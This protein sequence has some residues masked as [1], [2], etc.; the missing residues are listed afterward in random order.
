MLPPVSRSLPLA[1]ATLGL[2]AP[3]FADNPAAR[4]E[5]P[6]VQVVGTTPLPGIGVSLEKV[7]ANVQSVS[8]DDIRRQQPLDLSEQLTQNLSG[9]VASPSQNNPWQPDIAFRGFTASPLMGSPQGLSVFLDGVRVNESFGDT[10]NWDL[11]PPNAIAGTN[12]IPGS[13]PV[14]GLNTLGGTLAVQTKS[15]LKYPGSSMQLMG[16]SW[17]RRNAQF[18]TGGHQDGKD[19]FVAGNF[20]DEDG[21]RQHSASSVN[22]LF[23]KTGFEDDRNDLDVS[24][25]LA[26]NRLN[27]VQALPLAMLDNRRQ[28]YTWPDRTDNRLVMI[29]ARG[30]HFLSDEQ[31]VAGGLYLRSLDNGNLSSN[32]NDNY[33]PLGAPG[34]NNA[35]GTMDRSQTTSRSWGGSLQYTDTHPWHG[36]ENQ[37]TVGVS[38]DFGR[39]DYRQWSAPGDFT[40]DRTVAVT[41]PAALQ[42]AARTDNRYLGLY[43]TDTLSLS[44]R[45]HLTAAGR[46]NDARVTIRD[47]S[48]DNPALNGDHHF[49]RFNP[50]L[51]INFTPRPE[52]T[53]YAS[54]SEGMRVATPMELTCADP[55]IPCKLPN[56][57]LADPALQPVISHTWETGLRGKLG[58]ENGALGY[59]TS[60][61]R[62]D[63]DDDIQFISSNGAAVN[64]GYFKNVGRT[65]RQGLE[66]ALDTRRGDFSWN[67]GYSY[68]MA[69]Y[70]SALTLHSPANSS[71]NAAGD[72]QVR[73][74]N[75]IPLSPN[76][77]LRLRLDYAPG[78]FSI[79]ASLI[80]VGPQYA[81]GDANNQDANGKLPGYAVV[82]LDGHYRL[83]RE[84]ELLGKVNNLFDR[85]YDGMA[86][87]GQNFFRGPGGTFDANSAAAEQFRSPGAPRG[88]WLGLRY[89][90]PQH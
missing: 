56:A 64:S 26:D 80:V 70:E 6:T 9:V 15:G 54:Y 72:I 45:W 76:H 36:L 40:T 10:V 65:R 75:Q 16:G 47:A 39:S 89:T 17:G 58:G 23:A 73:P 24:L 42:T 8:A 71:A 27:G 14:F 66:L 83:D 34:P 13:N 69:T 55:A 53:A 31:L 50:A 62:T 48:G 85:R 57:F 19:Y 3:A 25:L 29:N 51:G 84:W 67:A 52:L 87:L 60:I 49:Q 82:N 68:L 61:F 11:I 86:V 79:G 90:W 1:W 78:P 59:R 12:V 41:G 46:W 37:A 2:V 5:A 88:I 20:A 28:A 81:Q 44:S 32:V 38:A 30:S 35:Q 21:W 22:Q 4:L 7:P 33:D 63:L 18:E 77:N 43:F 74:G